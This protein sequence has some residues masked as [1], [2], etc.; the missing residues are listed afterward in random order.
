MD[1]GHP[2]VK[3]KEKESKAKRAKDLYTEADTLLQERTPA[4][5][6]KAAQKLTEA[7]RYRPA[8][9][10]YFYARGNCY[11]FLGEYKRAIFDY[12][13]AIQMDDNAASAGGRDGTV[14]PATVVARYYGNRGACFRHLGKLADSLNDFNRAL[15]L[16]PNNG[17]WYSQ[18]GLTY[19]DAG[20]KERAVSCYT[21]AIERLS[22]H[23]GNE[24]L[25][26]KPRL[27]RG[28]TL[29][30]L[31]RCEE[32]LVDV[33][34]AC[35]I[36][37]HSSAVWNALGLTL[38]EMGGQ[39]NFAAAAA[40]F[41]RAIDA[42]PQRAL[43]FN[44][45]GLALFRL[46]KAVDAIQDF[47]VAIEQEE[48]RVNGNIF[49]NRGNAHLAAGHYHEALRDLDEARSRMPSDEGVYY[50]KG[51]CYLETGRMEEAVDAFGEAL[52]VRPNFVPALFHLGVAYHIA[53]A[54]F[55][56]ETALLRAAQI[57]R[58]DRRV[59]ESL[60]L[61]YLDMQLFD[62]AAN[63]F[64]DALR[65]APTKGSN[66]Y[67]LGR[68]LLWQGLYREA[69]EALTRALEHGCDD[70]LVLNTRGIAYRYCGEFAAAI[71]DLDA[72]V[73]AAPACIEFLFNRAMCRLAAKE[74]A[75]AEADLTAAIA[76]DA[77][78]PKLRGLRGK[79]RFEMARFDDCVD[80]M[81]A[82][83]AGAPDGEDAAESSYYLGMAHASMGRHQEAIAAFAQSIALRPNRANTLHERAKARQCVHDHAGAVEDFTA[84][85]ALQP[86]HAH[87]YFR[88]AF[89]YKNLG[90]YEAAA[91]DFET[92]KRI[93]PTNP[94]MVV[95]YR[96]VHDVEFIVLCP[97]GRDP[98]P[99]TPTPE[100]L[101]QAG[102]SS[103]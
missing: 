66:H 29:R 103:P 26:F 79:A 56:A 59:H 18:M 72:A 51:V 7:I 1:A 44:N 71:A 24:R 74:Y 16:D 75:R 40:A 76:V 37:D 8:F 94:H 49:Y 63:A 102:L 91:K 88:R 32:A 3:N 99:P 46:G 53:D 54:L 48:Q 69:V 23:G 12:T 34:A 61:V 42:E 4:A 68:A 83:L 41:S 101:A 87:A 10:R 52:R 85:L 9:A 30:E 28:N 67:Y 20:Q 19:Y 45:R 89:S 17:V 11:K 15:E 39:E 60:G 82:A 84:T 95:D 86:L 14:A 57:A 55:D 13:M 73:E 25:A 33:Y 6:H 70:P 62:L 36:D 96:S 22:A 92:A 58:D 65:I 97:P 98:P 38:F 27:Q 64:S 5:Y 2:S 77:A 50:A 31:G 35:Q 81:E 47:T 100:L 43:Y 78:E 80:D 21:S 93:Q 90:R